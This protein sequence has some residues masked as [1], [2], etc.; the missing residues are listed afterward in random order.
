[1]IMYNWQC[2]V[3][4][5]YPKTH[6]PRNS[7]WIIWTLLCVLT[8]EPIVES[9]SYCRVF[10]NNNNEFKPDCKILKNMIHRLK[11]SWTWK[12]GGHLFIIMRIIRQC[13]RHTWFKPHPTSGLVYEMERLPSK[14]FRLRRV[15]S[16]S[17]ELLSTT[18]RISWRALLL[19]LYWEN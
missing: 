17:E 4:L 7:D 15:L 12:V 13:F 19:A 6:I 3:L 1:M 9:R 14:R 5:Q 16:F 8:L 11:S 2:T 10:R 18:N